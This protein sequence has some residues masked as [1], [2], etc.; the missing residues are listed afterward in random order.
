[1]RTL[2]PALFLSLAT[3]ICAWPGTAGAAGSARLADSFPR[4]SGFNELGAPAEPKELRFLSAEVLAGVPYD[5]VAQFPKNTTPGFTVKRVAV[6]GID[7]SNYLVQNHGIL[8]GNR[9]VFGIE[10]FTVSLFADWQTGKRYEVVVEGTAESGRPV[11][12]AVAED[13]PEERE[14]VK[15]ASFGSPTP[16]MPYHHMDVV[17][18]KEVIP[19]G[20]VTLVEIDGKKC[21]DARFF[22][23]GK[24]HPAKAGQTN[25]IEGESYEGRLDGTRDFR[26]VVPVNW[27]NGSEHVVRVKVAPE[28]G[29]ETL[30]E[31]AGTGPDKGGFWD[32][33][34][35]HATSIVLR[36]T[37]G[38]LRQGEPVQVMVGFFADDITSPENEIRVVTYD[39]TSPKADIDGYVVAPCQIESATVWRD[40]KL[41]KAE[42]RDPETHELVHRYDPTTTV[43]LLFLADVQPYQEKVYQIVYGNPKAEALHP[44]SDL[45]VRPGGGLSQTVENS[46]Y[47]F[48]LST[49]SGSVE[50]VTIL[51]QG[52]PVPLEH[53]LE[54]NGAVHWNPD[55]YSPPL[56]WVHASDW[57][58]PDF[59]QHSGP[60]RHRTRRYAP[61][62]HMDS[63]VANVTYEFY[64]SQPYVI[65]SSFMEVQKEQFVQAL[66]NSEIVFNHAVLNEFVWED[67]LGKIQSLKIE[68]ARK[69]PIH[70]L[71]IPAD[72]PWMA[73]INREK[74]VGFAGITLA[75]NNGNRFGQP[76]SET[77]PYFYEQNGPWIYWARPNVYPFGGLNFTRMMPVRAG[78]FY[79]EKSAWVPFRLAKGD[80]PFQGLQRIQK[81]LTHPLL[82]HEWMATDDRTPEKWV[83][84]ILT[85]PFNEGVPGAVSGHKRQGGEE[86]MKSSKLQASVF[87]QPGATGARTFLSAASFEKATRPGQ[88]PTYGS[89][90][91]LLRTGMSARRPGVEIRPR[92]PSLPWPAYGSIDRGRDCRLL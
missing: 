59:E 39:P 70:A 4:P 78:S 88:F 76:P 54:S 50:Q 49:N 83:M 28:G 32:V 90:Q 37:A 81:T 53:K 35:P 80:T 14:Q 51:G 3:A 17:L 42:E 5:L 65:M 75:R 55:I 72:T 13:A 48:F 43:E 86:V 30:Y 15:G 36:E 89:H 67:P 33:G 68:A 2:S 19:P 63:V 34:G 58:K 92:K 74:G 45:K 79:Y 82:V 12:L 60:L 46:L 87:T 1:M 41:L 64:A 18:A 31:A 66:R 71:E 25:L 47:R 91:A 23:S 40:P 9:H 22:N 85:V 77:Q 73:F 61:L 8:N 84:P 57:E 44:P 38:I 20:K 6:N 16:E 56:P 27:T 10:D 7:Q 29:S 26:I 11:R 21:R 69:H 62:P 52:G 24:P